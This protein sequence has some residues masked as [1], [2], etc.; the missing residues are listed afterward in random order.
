MRIW[1]RPTAALAAGLGTSD[2]AADFRCQRA[3]VADGPL[4]EARRPPE[5]LQRLALAQLWPPAVPPWPGV[6]APWPGVLAPWPGVRA[7]WPGV[8]APAVPSP[9]CLPRDQPTVAAG[10]ALAARQVRRGRPD[11]LRAD[12]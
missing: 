8:R 7:P 10:R 4:A 3:L 12:S 1:R 6:L 5:T 11:S 2:G 9:K